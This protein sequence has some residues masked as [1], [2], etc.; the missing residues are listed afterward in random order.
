MSAATLPAGLVERDGG[1]G[2]T[3]RMSAATPPAALV[4]RDGGRGETRPMSPITPP[5]VP[6]R[7]AAVAGRHGP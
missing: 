6:G 1:R 7:V 4:E 5:A 2:E 3:R